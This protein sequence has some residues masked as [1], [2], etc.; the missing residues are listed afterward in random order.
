MVPLAE[1]KHMA[2]KL[3]HGAENKSIVESNLPPVNCFGSL[4]TGATNLMG[5]QYCR[6]AAIDSGQAR[7]LS[8]QK[9]PALDA[10]VRVKRQ[11]L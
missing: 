5:W 1:D 10:R 11:V 9:A 7:L 3:S 2:E 8:N 6:Q 4:P